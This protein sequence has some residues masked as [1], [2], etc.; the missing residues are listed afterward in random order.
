MDREISKSSTET[1]D[2]R[3]SDWLDRE[4]PKHKR[5][6]ESNPQQAIDDAVNAFTST[7]LRCAEDTISGGI[8][9][10]QANALRL[11]RQSR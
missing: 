10:Y 1:S 7:L 9:S 2:N 8:I 4:M 11:L 6:A 3:L 5:T